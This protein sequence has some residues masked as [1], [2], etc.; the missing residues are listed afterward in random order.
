MKK[1]PIGIR[2][3]AQMLNISVSTVSRALRDAWDVNPETR[4][5]VL[6]VAGQLN[7][8]PNRNA[9]ALASGNTRNIG[10]VIPFITNYYFSTVISGIQEVAYSNN[11]NII[12]LIT[13]DDPERE[14]KMIS[15]IPV[16]SLDG[17]LI[18]ISSGSVNSGHFKELAEE[19]I[20][21]VFF[22]KVPSDIEATKV[23]QDDFAGAYTATVHLIE[24]GY[25]HIAHIAGPE[26]LS[27]T[28][29]RLHGY[30]EALRHH[31]LPV[32]NEWILYSGFS[33]QCGTDDMNRLLDLPQTPDAVFAV[34]DRKAV[35]AIIALK[36]RQIIVG[37]DIGV[38]GFTNDPIA[39]II[40]PSLTTIE[41]PAFEIGRKSCELLIKH[42][43]NKNLLP[44]E[45]ILPGTLIVR[46]STKQ[47]SGSK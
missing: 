3:I 18:S 37:K 43:I 39:T 21:V 30:L 41:E 34:N 10:V 25:R 36:E 28:Q 33:Q 29:K 5:K 19:G 23:L 47:H 17:L 2:E 22:D 40:E 6:E 46:N 26:H 27:F 42:M 12:L 16:T 32:R 14:L 31:C 1:R 44:R 38:V 7:Y 20:P 24:Q 9:A 4:R 8:R 45:I 15:S 35:G 13:N 11:Y